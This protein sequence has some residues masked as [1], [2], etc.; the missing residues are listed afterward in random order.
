MWP[1]TIP[2]SLT[3]DALALIIIVVVGW[4]LIV[5]VEGRDT[6]TS[7]RLFVGHGG[8]IQRKSR[9][10]VWLAWI[11]YML[12]V[13]KVD[14]DSTG[15]HSQQVSVCF[16]S[17]CFFLLPLEGYAGRH[18]IDRFATYESLAVLAQ[19]LST[20]VLGKFNPYVILDTKSIDLSVSLIE[21]VLDV[22]CSDHLYNKPTRRVECRSYRP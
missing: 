11:V 8:M 9:V 3:V 14:G 10:N 5:V 7:A 13:R 4:V 20:Q 2:A 21:V 1:G 12:V 6:D 16:L 22:R 15:P 17:V 18:M 19:W